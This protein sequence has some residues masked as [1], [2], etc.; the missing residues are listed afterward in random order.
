MLRKKGLAGRLGLTAAAV[1]FGVAGSAVA[2]SGAAWEALE[3]EY[4]GCSRSNMGRW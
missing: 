3:L 2:Q 4:P 1:L